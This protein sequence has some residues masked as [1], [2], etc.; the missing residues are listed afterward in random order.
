MREIFRKLLPDH[1]SIRRHEWLRP[2]Q[3]L[4]HHPNLWH[5]HRRSVAGGVAIGLFCGMIPGP[6]QMISAALLAILFRVNLPVA[7]FTTFYTNPFTIV[8]LYLLAY[9]IGLVVSG[10]SN[11]TSVPEFPEVHW[12]EW[13]GEVW[14]WLMTL[15]KPLLIGL[16]ILA[17]GLAIAGYIAV[18]LVWRGVVVWKW[19]K[20][21]A[22]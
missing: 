17:I 2:I 8:P 10:T 5:L 7:A 6:L 21:H 22:R 11:A 20:R 14:G 12:L 9:K 19:S 13:F 3:H 16:P 4:L 1:D 15:G 18:R